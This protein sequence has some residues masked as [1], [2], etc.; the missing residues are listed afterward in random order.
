MSFSYY[1]FRELRF[2]NVRNGQCPSGGCLSSIVFEMKVKNLF[3]NFD[4]KQ[5][6][7]ALTSQ[8]IYIRQFQMYRITNPRFR[9][10]DWILAGANLL[11][12]FVNS[13]CI[14][15]KMTP[16]QTNSVDSLAFF[17]ESEPVLYCMARAEDKTGVKERRRLRGGGTGER[18]NRRGTV[19]RKRQRRRFSLL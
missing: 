14:R 15:S 9:S 2:D 16:L 13:S 18:E 12:G 11:I 8:K 10:P 7:L 3:A 6:T 5:E 4:A 1:G 19:Y 17:E